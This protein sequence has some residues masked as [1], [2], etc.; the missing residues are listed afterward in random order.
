MGKKFLARNYEGTKDWLKEECY[1]RKEV[2]RKI[3]KVFEKFGFE[4]LETPIIELK[5]T[6]TGK[7]GEEAEMLMYLFKRGKRWIGLRY[8]HTVPL[9]RVIAQHSAKIVLPY[10]RY[11]IGPVFRGERPQRGRYRQFIQCDFDIVGVKDVIADAEIVTLNYQILKELDFK[12]FE[13]QI[14]ERK[15]LTGLAKA[16]GAKTKE[17]ILTFLRTW[18]KLEKLTQKGLEEELK[19]AKTRKELI[20]KFFAITEKLLALEKESVLESLERLF[21]KEPLIKKGIE[22]LRKLTEYLDWFGVPKE[23]YR[24][25]PTLARGLDYY[26]GPIFE[27]TIKGAKIGSIAG[28]GRYDDLIGRL[29]GPEIPGTGCS[30]GLERVIEVMKKLK[31]APEIQTKTQ[32]FVAIFDPTSLECIE[33]AIQLCTKLREVGF[34]VEMGMERKIGKQ[35]K[36]ADKKKIPLAVFV[37]PKEIKENVV[38][39]KDLRVPFQPGVKNQWKV[40]EKK[41]VEKIKKLL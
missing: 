24:I 12:E 5:E 9:A 2:I 34:S 29:G 18:D 41:L 11:A 10:K 20:P 40:P 30:F 39:I 15:L 16:A 25:N 19:R 36:T 7:Y 35:L 23:Y 22:T 26:T 31:I 27:T 14:C 8:D 6:L 33:K 17:E 3:E 32:I 1:L 21:P 28:G 38:I 4:P 13:I 37:G